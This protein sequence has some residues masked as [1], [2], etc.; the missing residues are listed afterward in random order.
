MQAFVDIPIREERFERLFP[1]TN[2]GV[3]G[4]LWADDDVLIRPASWL[5]SKLPC[6]ADMLASLVTSRV[7]NITGVTVNA[8][9]MLTEFV[10]TA[11]LAITAFAPM[12]ALTHLAPVLTYD[13][14]LVTVAV[15]VDSNSSAV[16]RHLQAPQMKSSFPSALCVAIRSVSE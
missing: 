6:V 11:E 16:R 15:P 8:L 3:I 9:A 4:S 10:W 7:T 1:L 2:H 5:H 13:A 14:A 12:L